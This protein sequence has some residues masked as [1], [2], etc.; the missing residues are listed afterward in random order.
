MKAVRFNDLYNPVAPFSSVEEKI[1][2]RKGIKCYISNTKIEKGEDIYTFR[3]FSF[4]QDVILYARKIDFEASDYFINYRDC[5][6]KNRYSIKHFKNF[7]F[8]RHPDYKKVLNNFSFDYAIELITN[9]TTQPEPYYYSSGKIINEC[10]K[11]EKL[12]IDINAVAILISILIK[13]GYS[14]KILSKMEEFPKTSLPVFALL[15]DRRFQ[16]KVADILA[17]SDFPLVLETLKK[18]K[19]SL[20]DFNTLKSFSSKNES[21]IELLSLCLKKYQLHL[22]DGLTSRGCYMDIKPPLNCRLI[23]FFIVNPKYFP[24][25]QQ[26]INDKE[27]PSGFTYMKCYYYRAAM[28]HIIDN[29]PNQILPWIENMQDEVN[30]YYSG[31]PKGFIS[32]S[33]KMIKCQLIKNNYP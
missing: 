14:N 24:L 12:N 1:N 2:S 15:D 28:F 7:E 4:R 6:L 23:Y 16:N 22:L 27:L 5:Y 21:F 33:I 13:C 20:N 9:P 10:S 31:S 19:L 3:L 18:R 26:Y 29:Y 25:L 17:L 32:D 8:F 30:Y 11:E